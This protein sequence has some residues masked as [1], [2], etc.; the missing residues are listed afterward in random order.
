MSFQ[1]FFFDSLKWTCNVISQ[2]ILLYISSVTSATTT[3]HWSLS[4]YFGKNVSLSLFF[5][6]FLSLSLKGAYSVFTQHLL[7]RISFAS[8]ITAIVRQLF[9]NYI[10]LKLMDMPCYNFLFFWVLNNHLILRQPRL[11]IIGT[12]RFYHF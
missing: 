9:V 12:P 6:F 11:I 7:L 4:I 5:Q 10:V 2:H 3:N 8:G 1:F